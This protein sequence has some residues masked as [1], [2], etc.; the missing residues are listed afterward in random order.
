MASKQEKM[1]KKYHSKFEEI[2]KSAKEKD[3][4]KRE[5]AAKEGEEPIA[6]AP[7]N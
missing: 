2:K 6:E 4:A 5:K 7:R 3:K 1:L